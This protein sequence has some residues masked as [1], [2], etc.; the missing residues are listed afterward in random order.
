MSEKTMLTPMLL[1]KVGEVI[2]PMNSVV[3]VKI[4]NICKI[5]STWHKLNTLYI[6]AINYYEYWYFIQFS[7]LRERVAEYALH[8]CKNC[9]GF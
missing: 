1:S 7:I 8:R 4:D 6:L 3:R 5:L 9:F 2:G